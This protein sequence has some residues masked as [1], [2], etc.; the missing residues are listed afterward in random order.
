MIVYRKATLDDLQTVTELFMRLYKS[1]SYEYLESVNRKNLA[2]REQAIVLAQQSEKVV[3][4]A[5]SSIRH[6]YVE[7]TN[8]GNVGYLEGIFVL[9][10]FRMHGIAKSLVAECEKWAKDMGCVEFASDCELT[11]IEN[12]CFHLKIGFAEANR[13]ICF[14]KKL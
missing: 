1:R 4:I 9:P 12:G 6:D 13:I 5:H 2:D 10:E 8:G 7:G 3:G 14:T 11:K